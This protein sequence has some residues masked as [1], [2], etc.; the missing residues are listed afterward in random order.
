LALSP[1]TYH[2]NLLVDDTEWVVPGGVATVA[3]RLGGMLALL[4][5]Q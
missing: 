4:T 1:G 3:D 2:F 5:V